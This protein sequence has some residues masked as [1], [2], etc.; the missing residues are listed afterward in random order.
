M[1]KLTVLSLAA[2]LTLSSLATLGN[3]TKASEPVSNRQT[4]TSVA[5]PP[6]V[7]M[8]NPCKDF[9]KLKEAVKEAGFNFVFPGAIAGYKK[10][11]FRVNKSE[12]TVEVIFKNDTDEIRFRK[13]HT[14]KDISGDSGDYKEVNTVDVNGTEV[15]FKGNNKIIHLATWTKDG[16]SYSIT[17]TEGFEEAT[18]KLITKCMVSEDLTEWESAIWG[19]EDNVDMP[20]PWSEQPSLKALKKAAGFNM[21]IPK[22]IDGTKKKSFRTLIDGDDKLAE[23]S[24]VVGDDEKAYIRKGTGSEDVSGDSEDYAN[25]ITK[26]IGDVSVTMKGGK[27][28]N[29]AVWE[30]DGYSFALYVKKGVTKKAMIKLISQIK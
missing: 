8:P 28:L 21:S 14:T 2:A 30:K 1:K 7:G 23:V 5:T 4:F 22:S 24:Y 15:T 9:E 10:P 13:G 26:K 20:N 19:P 27:K 18:A 6:S 17:S 25:V 3:T 16:Y 29:L 12:E 11:I